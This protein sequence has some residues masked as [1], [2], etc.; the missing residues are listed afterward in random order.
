MSNDGSG[1]T[2]R[3]TGRLIEESQDTRICEEEYY[4]RLKKCK[5]DCKRDG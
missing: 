1:L 4:E 3:C 5:D 2:D